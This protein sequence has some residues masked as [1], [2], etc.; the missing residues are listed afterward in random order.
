M[1]LQHIAVACTGGSRVSVHVGL[2]TQSEAERLRK[3]LSDRYAYTR[4]HVTSIDRSR[5]Q[6]ARLI[7]IIALMQYT[8]RI[9]GPQRL[10]AIIRFDGPRPAQ[11][12]RVLA[13]GCSS[14]AHQKGVRAAA[15]AQAGRRGSG[16]PA[17][18]RVALFM[19]LYVSDKLLS[20]QRHP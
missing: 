16:A 20:E 14:L 2:R 18:F 3:C 19:Y 11:G 9:L 4:A 1:G 8:V 12:H 5:T 13:I 10:L 15:H 7:I 17:R 6:Y